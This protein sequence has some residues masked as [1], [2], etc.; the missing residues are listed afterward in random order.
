ME[1]T[2]TS[3]FEAVV[4][5]E[6]RQPREGVDS[7]QVILDSVGKELLDHLGAGIPDLGG[8]LE[9]SFGR[10]FQVGALA[11]GI[12]LQAGL[13]L[14]G[15]LGHGMSGDQFGGLVDLD[16]TAADIDLDLLADQT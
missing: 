9:A 13:T 8:F 14:P 3:L 5:I 4:S 12:V 1:G 16:D 15:M 6:D 2:Q 7:G 10:I 11:F